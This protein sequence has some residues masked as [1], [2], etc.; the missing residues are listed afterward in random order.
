ML[1]SSLF[2]A[3]AILRP[4]RDPIDLT[5]SAVNRSNHLR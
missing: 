2:S 4:A 1:S 5:A 3:N